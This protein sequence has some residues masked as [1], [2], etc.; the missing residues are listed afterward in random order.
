MKG[1]ESQENLV[2]DSESVLQTEESLDSQ[3]EFS[4][5][6]TEKQFLTHAERGDCASVR[7]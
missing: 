1:T 3:P 2:Q 6:L 7:R 4:L 5:T